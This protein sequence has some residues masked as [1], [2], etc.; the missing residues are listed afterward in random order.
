MLGLVLFLLYV[1]EL[2]RLIHSRVKMFTDDMKLYRA[3]CSNRD[4]KLLQQDL[5]TLSLWADT[6]L[7]KFNISKC[8]VMHCGA[9]NRKVT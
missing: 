8:K 3:I 6:W 7:L 2:P 1:N 9:S 4:T 5:D